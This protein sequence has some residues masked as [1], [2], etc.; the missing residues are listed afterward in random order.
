MAYGA[1][2]ELFEAYFLQMPTAML[3]WQH[4]QRRRR[5]WGCQ[6]GR[7]EIREFRGHRK[8]NRFWGHVTL[9][10]LNVRSLG[11]RRQDDGFYYSHLKSLN[12]DVMGLTE[13]WNSQKRYDSWDC[14]TCEPNHGGGDRP[15]GVCIMLSKRFASRQL[16]RGRIGTRGCWV[17]IQGPVCNLLI[18]C[19]YLPPIGSKTETVSLMKGLR[20]VLNDRSQ[21]DCVI[22]LGDFNIEFPRRYQNI[23]GPY[24]C[25]QGK[26]KMR[27]RT[28]DFLNL[29]EQHDLCVPSTYF[30]PKKRQNLYTW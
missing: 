3:H 18:I 14:V 12:H 11:R 9:A 28:K 1:K 8:F 5:E 26:I 7:E 4:R 10:T 27:R 15:A 2:F 6:G 16:N 25:A 30:R 17:R 23:I 20:E 22:L 19:I 13:M 29:F 21:H 24:A